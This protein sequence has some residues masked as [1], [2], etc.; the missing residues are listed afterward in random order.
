M[1]SQNT[2][3]FDTSKFVKMT[4]YIKKLNDPSPT[5]ETVI[6]NTELSLLNVKL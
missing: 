4:S 2:I 6:Y 5:V 3:Q 1:A